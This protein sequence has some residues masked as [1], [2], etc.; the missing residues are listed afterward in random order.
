M[1]HSLCPESEN[2]PLE[3]QQYLS[4]MQNVIHP[5]PKMNT[6]QAPNASKSRHWRVYEMVSLASWPGTI[7][8]ILTMQCSD[9]MNMNK[10]E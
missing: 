2:A 4:V 6:R 8:S 9:N 7:F 3:L 10:H 1:T 5:G